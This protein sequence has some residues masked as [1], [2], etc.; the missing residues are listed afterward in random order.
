MQKVSSLMT[1]VESRT[2]VV[3]C[4]TCTMRG[5]RW[6]LVNETT[7]PARQLVSRDKTQRTLTTLVQGFALIMLFYLDPSHSSL[8]R[9]SC[10]SRVLVEQY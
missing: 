2:M 6:R 9:Q 5:T 3:A 7:S 1:N 10:F 8:S 4:K